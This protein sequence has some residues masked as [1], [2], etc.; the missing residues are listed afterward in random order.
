MRKLIPIL[1][2]II[3]FSSCQEKL[4]KGIVFFENIDFSSGKYK[5]YV[6]A[7]KGKWIDD[8]EN[9]VIDDIETLNEIQKKWIFKNKV[10]PT[11]C[12]YGY[13]LKL[14]DQEKIIKSI[15]IN[16]DCE[17]MTGWIKFPKEYLTE[18]KNSFK[19]LDSIQI[20]EFNEKY[21]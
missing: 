10:P 5:I 2:F 21:K 15:R 13:K 9:F 17:F 8:Y 18:F 3:I 19:R 4:D 12:G 20:N 1:L 16:I 14:V 11:G 7:Q 6:F